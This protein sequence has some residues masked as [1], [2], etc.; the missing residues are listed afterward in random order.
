MFF[1]MGW[2][3]DLYCTAC[4]LIDGSSFWFLSFLFLIH[5][6]TTLPSTKSQMMPIRDFFSSLTSTEV[7]NFFAVCFQTDP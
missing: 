1:E 7:L 2:L 3:K 6:Y 5:C 4:Q